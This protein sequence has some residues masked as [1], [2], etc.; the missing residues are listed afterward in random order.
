MTRTV[1]I[2]RGGSSSVEPACATGLRDRLAHQDTE[3]DQRP[4]FEVLQEDVPDLEGFDVSV[5]EPTGEV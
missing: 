5:A 3:I 1:R 2:C 4:L